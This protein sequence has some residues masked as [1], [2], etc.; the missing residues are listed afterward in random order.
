M[1]DRSLEND[2]IGVFCEKCAYET[3][4]SVGWLRKHTQVEC[5]S[6]GA[7]IDVESINFRNIAPHRRRGPNSRN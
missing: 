7:I 1:T 2:E 6:C 3:R 5:V 4:R